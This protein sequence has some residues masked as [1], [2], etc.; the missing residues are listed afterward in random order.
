MLAKFF[1]AKNKTNKSIDYFE[2]V[3]TKVQQQLDTSHPYELAAHA[4]LVELYE[5]KGKSEDA[6]KHCVAIGKMTPWSDDIEPTPLYRQD[7]NYPKSEI[8]RKN[9][10]WVEL[11]FVIDSFGFVKDIQVLETSSNSFAKEGVKALEK[12]RYAPKI[13]DGQAV[14]SPKMRVRLDFIIG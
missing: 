8:K 12:W 6:T 11:G 4:S 14:V 7:P 13:T 1:R 3:V 2:K 5:S 10:G 9:D